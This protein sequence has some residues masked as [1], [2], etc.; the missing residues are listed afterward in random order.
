MGKLI[1]LS[2]WHHTT[3]IVG[4]ALMGINFVVDDTRP[5]SNFQL[6][7]LKR[8]ISIP[9]KNPLSMLITSEIS[10]WALTLKF[11]FGELS[12]SSCLATWEISLLPK[13]WVTTHQHPCELSSNSQQIWVR[14]SDVSR[15]YMSKT[16]AIFLKNKI[17]LKKQEFQT[18]C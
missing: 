14:T 3:I 4:G 10:H 7:F 5:N 12:S 11:L 9:K 16:K 8:V 6:K 17:K 15:G 18:P 13:E 2:H 1:S